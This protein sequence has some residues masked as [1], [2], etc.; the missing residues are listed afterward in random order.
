MLQ[1]RNAHAAIPTRYISNFVHKTRVFGKTLE[2]VMGASL[3]KS[4]VEYCLP[5]EDQTLRMKHHSLA[6]AL[7]E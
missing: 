5:L 1:R 7:L 2:S 4:I 6:E 3:W